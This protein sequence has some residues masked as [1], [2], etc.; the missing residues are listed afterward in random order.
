MSGNDHL[1]GVFRF[2]KWQQNCLPFFGRVCTDTLLPAFDFD[3][4]VVIPCDN[5]L[6]LGVNRT[7]TSIVI[8]DCDFLSPYNQWFVVFV[9]KTEIRLQ[10][11]VTGGFLRIANPAG[12]VDAT[13]GATDI[14]TLFNNKGEDNTVVLESKVFPG[15]YVGLVA[16]EI[17]GT[18]NS[19]LAEFEYHSLPGINGTFI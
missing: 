4:T 18:L 11:E 2:C 15:L 10:N 13:G 14:D 8:C 9:S 17:E 7:N 3:T 12:R 6:Y 16:G 1:A 19:S 5:N